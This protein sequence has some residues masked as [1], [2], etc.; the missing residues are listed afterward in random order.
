MRHQKQSTANKQIKNPKVLENSTPNGNH[1]SNIEVAWGWMVGLSELERGNKQ[2][3]SP[4]P[5]QQLSR[6]QQCKGNEGS[7]E[8]CSPHRE[9]AL[10]WH[11][12]IQKGPTSVCRA[13][14]CSLQCSPGMLQ[15]SCQPEMELTVGNH[16]GQKV[17][18]R[19]GGTWG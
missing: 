3:R 8:G 7:K 10:W 1:I 4:R 15:E 9:V 6:L 14:L 2:V 5:P 12:R 11:H 18:R 19:S 13:E 17:Q 16:K